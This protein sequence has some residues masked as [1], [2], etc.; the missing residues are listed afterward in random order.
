M[1]LSSAK[2]RVKVSVVAVEM[3]PFVHTTVTAS[4]ASHSPSPMRWF[5]PRV[6]MTGGSVAEVGGATLGERTGCMDEALANGHVHTLP[7]RTFYWG[8]KKKY[9]KTLDRVTRLFF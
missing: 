5:E 8:P 3:L 6:G 1:Q 2:A 7:E 9:K 4:D